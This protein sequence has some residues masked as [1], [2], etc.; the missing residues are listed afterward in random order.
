MNV[1]NFGLL[2]GNSWLHTL[3]RAWLG[4]PQITI[5]LDKHKLCT[6]AYACGSH[7]CFCWLV[8]PVL[9]K[10]TSTRPGTI[11]WYNIQISIHKIDPTWVVTASKVISKNKTKTGVTNKT[12]PPSLLT[13]LYYGKKKTE[14]KTEKKNIGTILYGVLY[15]Y[16]VFAPWPAAF[17]AWLE[18]IFIHSFQ[19]A[20]HSW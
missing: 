17:V 4:T 15:F 6:M 7:I 3:S 9:Q 5:Q 1:P 2:A 20:T 16:S 13:A 12:V 18:I 19:V 8:W 11:S 14:K 10:Q